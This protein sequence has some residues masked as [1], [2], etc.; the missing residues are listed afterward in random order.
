MFGLHVNARKLAILLA[1]LILVAGGLYVG[2]RLQM[3]RQAPQVRFQL[4]GFVVDRQ[5]NLNHPPTLA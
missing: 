4:P 2:H 1:G 5:D 3:R